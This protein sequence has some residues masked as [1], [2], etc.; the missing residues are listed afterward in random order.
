MQATYDPNKKTKFT[1]SHRKE[2]KCWF[3]QMAVV[4]LDAEPYAGDG[5]ATVPVQARIYSTG[6][7]STCCLWVNTRGIN[8][9]GSGKAGGYGYHKGS[10]A[11][12][13]AIAN[14][15]FTLSGNIGGVGESAMREALLAI[16]TAIGI[17]RPALVEAYQ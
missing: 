12:E 3:K 11:L 9:S 8:T 1:N 6:A 14:A 2:G 7:T 4:D 10:V 13:F 16:A 15:G 5:S 17:K